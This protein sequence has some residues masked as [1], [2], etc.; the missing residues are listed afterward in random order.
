MSRPKPKERPPDRACHHDPTDG[1]CGV[2]IWV[3]GNNKPTRALLAAFDA[4]H[5]ADGSCG[6]RR[7]ERLPEDHGDARW[8]SNGL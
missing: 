7:V 6:G 2:A 4:A 8:G 1:G 5:P 3:E